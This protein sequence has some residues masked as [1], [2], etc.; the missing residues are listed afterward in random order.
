MSER[1]RALPIWI[2]GPVNDD[3]IFEK[4]APRSGDILELIPLCDNNET[5]QMIAEVVY[6]DR[7]DKDSVLAI[8]KFLLSDNVETTSLGKIFVT[9]STD[10]TASSFHFGRQKKCKNGDDNATHVR[11]RRQIT[12]DIDGQPLSD[13]EEVPPDGGGVGVSVLE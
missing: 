2:D 6:A 7:T 4:Y 8:L 3:D 10:G 5:A 12:G 13:W 11:K 9:G 1:R